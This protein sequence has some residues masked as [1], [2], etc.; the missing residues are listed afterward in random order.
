MLRVALYI[1]VS[2][3]EQALHGDSIE[4]QKQTLR[5]YAEKNQYKIIDYYIDDGFTATSLNRPNLQ[6]LLNDIK[7][8]KVDLVI[9]TKI[10]RWSR[11]VRNYYKIQDVLDTH[12][13]HWKTI[14]E[15][16]DTST[17]AGQLHINIMLSVAE[18]EAAVT[19]ERI[20]AV[21]N[22]KVKNK[23]VITGKVPKGYKI[24]N[25]K[26]VIDKETVHIVENIFSHFETHQSKRA[27]MNFLRD[28][29]GINLSYK[30]IS[31]MLRNSLY[32][33]E[34]RGI[35]DYCPSIIDKK[36]FDKIQ[37]LLKRNISTNTSNRIYLFSS[38]LVCSHCNHNIG[39]FNTKHNDKFFFNYRCN[40]NY[41]RKLC[42]N[43]RCISEKKLE[44]KVIEQFKLQLHD[45]IVDYEFKKKNKPKKSNKV[46]I[47]NKIKKLN[48]LYINDF[49][50]LEEYKKKHE[51]YKSKII[52]DENPQ[53]EFNIEAYKKMLNIDFDEKYIKLDREDKRAFWRSFI[54]E[55]KVDH[56]GNV[57]LKFH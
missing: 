28:E 23:E 17:A 3:E 26:L 2:T 8:G 19:S 6:R 24:E 46:E 15:N 4:A 40:Y 43:N 18:N 13:V 21:F 29:L 5:D 1:R 22:N 31:N 9:F 32:K 52:E 41:Y 30:T 11:G 25:K 14:F 45:Y 10:D 49:I 55:I 51:F 16:Y 36:R 56:D 50:T 44:R 35:V 53:D 27:T 39:G 34:Y 7:E 38:L 37:I 20:K 12:K 54:E 48:D 42:D 57:K 33:G 47:E